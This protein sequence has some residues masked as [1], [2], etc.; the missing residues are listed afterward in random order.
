MKLFAPLALLSAT[1]VLAACETPTTDVVID[2]PVLTDQG[3]VDGAPDA[4]DSCGAARYAALV[5]QTL[6]QITVP[7]GTVHRSLRENDPM[8]LDLQPE[9]INFL[10][11]RSGKLLRVTCG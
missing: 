1:L 9:R 10:Y 11:D 7:A 6:P 4:A 2:D 5:G 8:T 3:V